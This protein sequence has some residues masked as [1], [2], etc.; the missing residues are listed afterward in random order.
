MKYKALVMGVVI[1][2]LCINVHASSS[3]NKISED[4]IKQILCGTWVNPEY[5]EGMHCA[6]NI[7][8]SDGNWNAY[9]LYAGDHSYGGGTFVIERV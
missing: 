9:A 3:K 5:S 8:Y 2:V 4:E 6:K 1:I 7:Y